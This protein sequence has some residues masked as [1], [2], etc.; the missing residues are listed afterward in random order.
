MRGKTGEA[1]EV[2]LILKPRATD[3]AA[4]LKGLAMLYTKELSQALM[5]FLTNIFPRVRILPVANLI[6]EES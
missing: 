4:R 1:L 5:P 3:P 6:N 2:L